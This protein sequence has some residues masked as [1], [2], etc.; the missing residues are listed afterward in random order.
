VRQVGFPDAPWWRAD[1]E[2]HRWV[3]LI[4]RG[5]LVRVG[6]PFGLVM[7]P[8]CYFRAPETTIELSRNPLRIYGI[9]SRDEWIVVRGR[10]D[11]R[12]Q[13]AMTRK[14]F[15]DDV[16]KAWSPL[17]LSRRPT[18]L[19]AGQAPWRWRLSLGTGHAARRSGPFMAWNLVRK[20]ACYGS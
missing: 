17:A 18:A 10:Q 19:R 1:G 20:F 5:N 11:G 12:V 2:L 7:F 9:D 3:D 16:W 14:Y 8:Q 6:A 4:I 15:I 13:L